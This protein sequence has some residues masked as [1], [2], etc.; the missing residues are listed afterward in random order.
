MSATIQIHEMIALDTGVDRTS[1]TIRFKAANDQNVDANAPLVIPSSGQVYSYTKQVRAYMSV[2][3]NTNVQNIRYYTNGSNG[4][5]T[6]VDVQ[7]KNIGEA[8][9]GQ[10]ITPM[11]GAGQKSIFEWVSGAPCYANIVDVGP[12]TPTELNH[13]IGDTIQL[14]MVADSSAVSGTLSAQSLVMAYDE[15]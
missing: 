11:S 3:P 15:I 6:G 1:A 12:W 10:I 5:G 2:A 9:S 14:Q 4:F 7:G 8:Y 13:H